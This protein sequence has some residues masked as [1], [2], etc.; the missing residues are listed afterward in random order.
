MNPSVVIATHQRL[1]I[2]TRNI[3][4]L[5]LQTLVPTIILVVS[6]YSEYKY[7]TRLN[8]SNLI[9][10][11]EGNTPLGKKWQ[12]GVDK[13]ITI[14]ADPVI[15]CGSDDILENSY[16]QR[17][18]NFIES[19]NDFVGLRSWYIY[20]T[21]KLYQFNYHARIPLGGGRAY[22]KRF[23]DDIALEIFD[24]S[25]NKHLDDLGYNRVQYAN[26][27]KIILNDPAILSIKG[28]WPVINKFQD[29]FRSP[30]CRLV[31]EVDKQIMLDR[32]NYGF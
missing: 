19:G 11:L 24:L 7:Y 31:K 32:F 13:A 8:K 22:S 23:L 9:V 15:I 6:D 27:K 17:C 14:N 21:K 18:C 26:A 12:A 29:F 28:D 1:E 25:S 20:D 4:T 10:G 30:N 16:V 3:E 2:T 5:C